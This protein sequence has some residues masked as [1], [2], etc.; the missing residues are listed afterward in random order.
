MLYTLGWGGV[1]IRRMKLG[2]S[3]K[4]GNFVTT[5]IGS[6]VCSSSLFHGVSTFYFTNQC[7]ISCRYTDIWKPLKLTRYSC[8]RHADQDRTYLNCIAVFQIV[9]VTVYF[10]TFMYKSFLSE[11]TFVGFCKF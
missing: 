3:Y 6:I 2:V 4:A 1:G 9:S 7:T 5:P 8:I 10:H 11:T